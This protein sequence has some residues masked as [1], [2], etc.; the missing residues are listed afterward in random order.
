MRLVTAAELALA[1]SDLGMKAATHP[2]GRIGIR[3]ESAVLQ[4][5]GHIAECRYTAAV[6][7]EH[8]ADSDSDTAAAIAGS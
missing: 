3:R 4:M 8:T 1:A 6:T 7:T 5:S 2:A